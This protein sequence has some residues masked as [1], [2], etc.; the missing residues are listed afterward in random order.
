[1]RVLLAALALL[2][3]ATQSQATLPVSRYWIWASDMI[4]NQ[5][6]R[7]SPGGPCRLYQGPMD[8]CADTSNNPSVSIWNLKLGFDWGNP[9]GATPHVIE[10]RA[11]YV[12]GC[13]FIS[14]PCVLGYAIEKTSNPSRPLANASCTGSGCTC[15]AGGLEADL[16]CSGGKNNGGSCTDCGN[17]V[18]AAS[19][20]KHQRQPIYAGVNGFEL[21]LTYNTYD[22][23]RHRFGWH[24]RDSFNRA[25]SR[26]GSSTTAIAYRPDGKALQFTLS[27][28]V[29]SPDAGTPDRLVQTT[30][31]AGWQLTT[32]SS[33]E[34]ETYDSAGKL[35]TIKARSGLTQT[36]TYSDGTNGAN[37]GVVLDA[38]GN[39]TS[40]ILAAGYLI[41]AADHFGRTISFGY[42]NTGRV[43]KVTD[44]A[45]GVYRFGYDTTNRLTTITFPDTRVVTS[46]YNESANTSSTD[47]P[48]A[49]TGI[50]DENSNRFATFKYDAQFRS[51][52]TEHAGG[53]GLY[54]FSYSAGSTAVTRPLGGVSTYSI[55]NTL[56]AL[57]ASGI[58]GAVCPEC[59]PASQTFDANGNVATRTDWNGNRTNYS[60]DLARNLETSRTEALTSAGSTTPQTRTITTQWDTNF[61]LPTGIAEPLRI[62]TMAYDATGSTCGAKGAMCSRTLQATTD[63]DGSQAFSA[64]TTG[65][66][67]TWT[68]TYNANGHVLTVNGPRTDV[69]DVTTYTYY[70][71]NDATPGKRGNVATI[72]NA[73]SQV[74]Q[75]TSYNAHGQPLTIVDPN[76]LTTTLAYDSRQRLTSRTV[77]T[78]VTTYDYDF[79]GQLTKITLPDSSYL[80]YT[81]DNAHRVTGIQDNLSN[82]VTYTLDAAGNRTQEQVKDPASTLVQTRSRVYSNLDRLYQELGATSQTTEYTYDNQ[83]NVLTVKDPL[84]QTTTN[85]YDALNRL[86]QVTDPGTGVTQYA[87]NGVD[88]LTQVTDPRSLATGNTVDGLG[89][90]TQQSSPDTGTTASTYDAAGNLL[91]QTDAK[92]QITT[93]TYDALNRVTLITFHDG[94]T[95]TYAYDSGTNGLGRLSS[96]TEADPSSVQTSLT[97]YAY[98]QHGRVTSETRT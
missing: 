45:S 31:P 13:Q 62:T 50:V 67:R 40:F 32:A 71:N 53:A 98:N 59:G 19:G 28:G 16:V 14:S 91:T 11:N 92:N 93:Y 85:Q 70:A 56:G 68:Y 22:Q 12:P 72:T 51:I 97:A 61:R 78:E 41:R 60:Y 18:N 83:G 8:S 66:P 26:I 49:L 80:T 7:V 42:D 55:Q 58:T 38:S 54:Q 9:S 96:I 77:G 43:I 76:G 79:A 10:C 81:Y 25:I 34:V 89:N 39:P 15:N 20:N 3:I 2:S 86:K 95:Q 75:I 87:Y 1:M 23:Y 35:L 94:S 48:T 24:W 4:G 64:T 21:S 88:A 63:T 30:S 65:S 69:T 27:A 47:L 44:P 82:S 74:T 6:A 73:L 36:L 90:L 29:W 33:D 37:G 84:N 46:V 57:G 52:S 17:P 5:C